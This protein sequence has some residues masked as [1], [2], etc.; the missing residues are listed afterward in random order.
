MKMREVLD[1][2]HELGAKPDLTVHE[3]NER[4]DCEIAL[5]MT[6]A[7]PKERAEAARRVEEWKA[8]RECETANKEV[9]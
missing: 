2:L 9:R 4:R 6:T 7:G 8:K 1:R 5:G 3:M